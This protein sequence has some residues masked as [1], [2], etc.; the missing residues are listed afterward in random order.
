MALPT[1][2]DLV[3]SITNGQPHDHWMV[4]L[5]LVRLLATGAPVSPEQLALSLHRSYDE[6]TVALHQFPTVE[7]DQE[8]HIVGVGLSLVPTPHQLHIGDQHLFTWCA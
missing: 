7:Y 3:N 4:H 1:F 2:D 8:G 5:H 6:V